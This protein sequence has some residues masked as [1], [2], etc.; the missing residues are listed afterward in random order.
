MISVPVLGLAFEWQVWRTSYIVDSHQF[1]SNQAQVDDCVKYNVRHILHSH[2]TELG[3]AQI[4]GYP[5]N[6]RFIITFA[7]QKAKPRTCTGID[8]SWLHTF[9]RSQALYW[10]AQ[11]KQFALAWKSDQSSVTSSVVSSQSCGDVLLLYNV[12]TR[13]YC[14]QTFL[15]S[16]FSVGWIKITLW[17]REKL[18]RQPCLVHISLYSW[19]LYPSSIQ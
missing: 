1:G 14:P 19:C 7:T 17:D 13:R 15:S 9:T 16:E 3:L 8:I 6:T 10:A 4:D 2:H 12:K 11:Q 18:D 5:Q